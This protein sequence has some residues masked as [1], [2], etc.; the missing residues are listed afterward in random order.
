MEAKALF[1]ALQRKYPGTF[2]EGQ[3]RTFQRRVKAWRL[4]QVTEEHKAATEAALPRPS[5]HGA[6]P[7][8]RHRLGAAEK[9]PVQRE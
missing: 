3:L 9:Q 7:S 5:A 2:K 1:Q 6:I 4:K 8:C